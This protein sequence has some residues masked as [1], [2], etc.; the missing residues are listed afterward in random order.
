MIFSVDE[1][2]L[3]RFAG[4]ID[5]TQIKSTADVVVSS[6]TVLKKSY[7]VWVMKVW[8]DSFI[9]GKLAIAGNGADLLKC[10]S[11]DHQP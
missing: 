9:V 2:S 1:N 4:T 6:V 8:D 3:F 11:S 10:V 7:N 5:E